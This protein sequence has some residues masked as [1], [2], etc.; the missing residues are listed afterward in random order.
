MKTNFYTNHT[1]RILVCIFSFL[2]SILNYNQA[3]AQCTGNTMQYPTAAVT[4]PSN[5]DSTVT[6]STCNY[7]NEH[8]QLT[9]IDSGY[10]YQVE[11]ITS[12]GWLVVYEG[13]TGLPGTNATF[14][15]HGTSPLTFTAISN[16]DHW[17]HWVADSNCTQVTGVCNV[18]QI[19]IISG[20]NDVYG[21]RDSIAMNY[22]PLATCDSTCVY[23][24]GCM[25]SSATNYDPLAVMNDGSCIY[26]CVS[27]Y[28]SESF[29]SG[30][31]G[32]FWYNDFT[33]NTY[34]T[35]KLFQWYKYR[36][37]FYS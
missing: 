5:C 16:N 37:V 9:G 19:S 18:T 22:N 3:N 1:K 35:S 21:C 23:Y 29:E 13:A 33:N 25:D 32:T 30:L 31:A 15:A 34:C 6:I 36:C 26:A 28:Q 14:V 2:F 12:G 20:G 17:V 24:L 8:S 11:N 10:T 27:N 4:V 7:Q